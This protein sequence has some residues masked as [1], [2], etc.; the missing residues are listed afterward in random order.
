MHQKNSAWIPMKA[1]NVYSVVMTPV[2]RYRAADAGTM[3]WQ[4]VNV[5]SPDLLSLYVY[6]LKPATRY[7]FMVAARGVDT[8]AILFSL[9]LNATTK[10]NHHQTTSPVTFV[11]IT[12]LYTRTTRTN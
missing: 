12:A 5:N 6:S 4:T 11:D 2:C 8:G 7:Q 9:P 1:V 3:E 10:G